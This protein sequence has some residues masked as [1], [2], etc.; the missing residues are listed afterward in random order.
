M[1]WVNVDSLEDSQDLIKKINQRLA[2]KDS[3]EKP[4]SDTN[5]YRYIEVSPLFFLHAGNET[6][7]TDRQVA[8]S[9]IGANLRASL[10][11]KLFMEAGFLSANS[12]YPLFASHFTD[13]VGIVPGEGFARPTRLGFH[14]KN[15]SGYISYSP[16]RVFNFQLGYGKNFFGDGYRSLLLSDVANN[17]SF[18]RITTTIWKI[19]YVNLFANFKDMRVTI[20]DY[21]HYHDKYGTFHYLS[22]NITKWLNAGL[23][24]SVIWQ[25]KDTLSKRGFDVNYMNPAVFYRPV[26]YS[27]GSADNS[28]LGLNLKIKITNTFQLYSQIILDE[29]LLKEIKARSGWWANKY[30]GQAGFKYFNAFTLKGLF[31]Q[32]EF[33][34]IRPFTYSH[35]STLQNYAHFNQP[36]AHPLG[37][38]FYE[39]LGIARYSRKGFSV[40]YKS[41][42]SLFGSDP[43]GM[44]Y[45]GDVYKSYTKP[46]LIYGNKTG[47]G[48]RNY[49]LSNEISVSYVIFPELNLKLEIGALSRLKYSQSELGKSNY[50]WVGIK[51]SLYNIY[52]DFM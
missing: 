41:V 5:A 51:T 13:S 2:I 35:G 32:G 11:K 15:P 46:S 4:K 1:D 27:V 39:M 52:R 22:W 16:S 26:E 9:A 38:N 36:L 3:T 24:E 8:G 17:Y 23:F 42:F 28:L 25:G 44:N 40:D 6:G 50:Y 10:G 19:K 30:G 43:P 12:S 48:F 33:N 18:F 29:F 34:T 31:L 49:L 37:A 7:D 20:P 21:W 14:Y 47:Q 45:G